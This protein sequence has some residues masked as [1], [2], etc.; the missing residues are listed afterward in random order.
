MDTLEN[1]KKSH[2]HHLCGHYFILLGFVSTINEFGLYSLTLNHL[3]VLSNY[4]SWLL[5][6]QFLKLVILIDF[7]LYRTFVTTL[8]NVIT[9]SNQL[10]CLGDINRQYVNDMLGSAL[11]H[12]GLYSKI[13]KI[14]FNDFV[15]FFVCCLC[16]YIFDIRDGSFFKPNFFWLWLSKMIEKHQTLHSSWWLLLMDLC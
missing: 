4:T 11:K 2:L 1:Q 14:P 6:W 15:M 12:M 7:F 10:F 16:Q 8:S 3:I 5:F 9:I 13:P